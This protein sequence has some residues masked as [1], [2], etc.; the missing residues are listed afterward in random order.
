MADR[1]D[2]KSGGGMGFPPKAEWGDGL[3]QG[4]DDR[5]EWRS[6]HGLAC[7]I[8][9]G[10][11]GAL[12]GYVGVPASHPWHGRSY[13]EIDVS[14]HGGLTYSSG[15]QGHI[16]HTP[17]EGEAEVWWLGFDCAHCFDLAPAMAALLRQIGRG[18]DFLDPTQTYKP[19]EY[20]R[21]EVERLAEQVR[22]AGVE[23]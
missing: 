5:Y 23:R 4:E 11:G 22:A 1:N 14:V 18:D 7:L 3:W 10:P 15:C 6:V 9:R 20:V 17:L 19:V 12:C 16:C 2:R 13:Q 21:G 8:V